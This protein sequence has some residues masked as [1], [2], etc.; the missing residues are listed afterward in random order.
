MFEIFSTS[1]FT[2]PSQSFFALKAN[3]HRSLS[4]LLPTPWYHRRDI[5]SETGYVSA[6]TLLSPPPVGP[7]WGRRFGQSSRSA[8]RR[9]KCSNSIS[10]FRLVRVSSWYANIAGVSFG[11]STTRESAKRSGRLARMNSDGRSLLGSNLFASSV[12]F[13]EL[14]TL[15]AMQ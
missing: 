13:V 14:S 8:N 2:F 10:C 4:A 6:S 9:P 5:S 15:L 1:L 3:A 7:V 11:S 12:A